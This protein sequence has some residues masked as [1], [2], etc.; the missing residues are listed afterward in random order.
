MSFVLV[1]YFT[2]CVQN[3]NIDSAKNWPLTKL[4][5]VDERSPWCKVAFVSQTV[6]E[7]I[8]IQPSSRNMYLFT[9]DSSFYEK[10]YSKETAANMRVSEWKKAH[11]HTDTY[12]RYFSVF[13][14]PHFLLLIIVARAYCWALCKYTWFLSSASC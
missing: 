7:L 5:R 14:L 2:V 12:R 10:R 8:R 1:K 4:S 11:T 6:D 3:D 13:F 9:L